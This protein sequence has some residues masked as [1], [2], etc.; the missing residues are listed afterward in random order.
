MKFTIRKKTRTDGQVELRLCLV[1]SPEESE[2]AVRI[3]DDPNITADVHRLSTDQSPYVRLDQILCW[4]RIFVF[5][6]GVWGS[7]DTQ[8][9]FIVESVQ[10]K[11]GLQKKRAR[12]SRRKKRGVR[13]R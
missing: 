1:M 4:L 9:A 2:G 5:W 12:T 6:L 10:R 8:K 11:R 7:R 13:N 3:S